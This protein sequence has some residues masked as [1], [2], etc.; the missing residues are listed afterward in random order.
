MKLDAG[1]DFLD[2]HLMAI[3]DYN[4]GRRTSI[5]LRQTIEG[6]RCAVRDFLSEYTVSSKED[7]AD[8]TTLY[9]SFA[10]WRCQR[11]LDWLSLSDFADR[12]QAAGRK[13][14]MVGDV[15]MVRGVRLKAI[16]SKNF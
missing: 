10:A 5:R 4:V 16:S 7:V 15:A 2:A 1:N 14:T 11:R 9:N 6:R 3:E 12:I 8:L 13:V